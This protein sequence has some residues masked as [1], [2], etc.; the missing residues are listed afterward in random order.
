V[1][2]LANARLLIDEG[3]RVAVPDANLAR[4]ILA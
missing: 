2:D 4:Q 3:Q 1:T